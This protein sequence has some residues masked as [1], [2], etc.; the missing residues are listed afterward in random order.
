MFVLP[1]KVWQDA[2]GRPTLRETDVL[3]GGQGDSI[4]FETARTL[5]LVTKDG[6]AREPRRGRA[7]PTDEPEPDEPQEDAT[8]GQ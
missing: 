2:D 8:D 3:I 4:P 1:W 6:T 5:G 7:R